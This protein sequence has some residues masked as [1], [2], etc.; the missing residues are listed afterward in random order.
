MGGGKSQKDLASSNSTNS[1]QVTTININCI[2]DKTGHQ[3]DLFS[4]VQN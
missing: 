2:K 4:G 1:E 3:Y